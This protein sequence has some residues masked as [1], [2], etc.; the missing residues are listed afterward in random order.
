M[1]EPVYIVALIL[2]IVLA[3]ILIFLVTVDLR[4]RKFEKKF[5]EQQNSKKNLEAAKDLL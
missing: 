4:L 1:N 5:K 3:G 2:S